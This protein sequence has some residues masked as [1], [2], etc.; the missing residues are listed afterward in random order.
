[1]FGFRN[2]G[3]RTIV[4]FVLV[5]PKIV[6]LEL[7]LQAARPSVSMTV[8]RVIEDPLRLAACAITRPVIVF[9]TCT[10]SDGAARFTATKV[11]DPGATQTLLVALNTQTLSHP[12][13]TF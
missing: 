5:Y 9:A 8:R 11:F 10:E 2:V 1:L 13:L 3:A 6:P 4:G 12:M 7:G